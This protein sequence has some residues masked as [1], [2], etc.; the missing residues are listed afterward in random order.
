MTLEGE[1]VRS[2]MKER[3]SV[4]VSG[5]RRSSMMQG[6]RDLA[7][8][9]R[10]HGIAVLRQRSRAMYHLFRRK[11][12]AIGHMIV[13][14]KLW[15]K[16]IEAQVRTE[17]WFLMSEKLLADSSTIVIPDAHEF[18]TLVPITE[19]NVE[20]GKYEEIRFNK[21]HFKFDRRSQKSCLSPTAREFLTTKPAGSRSPT[22]IAEIVR[23][24]KSFASFG[25]FP[26]EL[27]KEIANSAI[28]DCYEKSRILSRC[29]RRPDGWYIVLYGQLLL[30]PKS[31]SGSTEAKVA[32]VGQIIGED[33]VTLNLPRSYT[34]VTKDDNT[35]VLYICKQDYLEAKIRLEGRCG[36]EDV[37]KTFQN[38]PTL[39]HFDFDI[40]LTEEK[41]W[42][43]HTYQTGAIIACQRKENPNDPNIEFTVSNLT[44]SDLMDEH[45]LEKEKSS[46]FC[47]VQKGSADIYGVCSETDLRQK[48][49]HKLALHPSNKKLF[50]FLDPSVN[51]WRKMNR[52]Y[53]DNEDGNL[54]EGF[55]LLLPENWSSDERSCRPLTAPVPRRYQRHTPFMDDP[56]LSTMAPI[57]YQEPSVVGPNPST[58]VNPSWTSDKGTA[59]I[60]VAKIGR[61]EAGSIFGLHGAVKEQ[62]KPWLK[63]GIE[64]GIQ[65]KALGVQTP[66]DVYFVSNGCQVILVKK[67]VYYK[68]L[69]RDAKCITASRVK[70]KN[71]KLENMWFIYFNPSKLF[72]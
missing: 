32:E 8:F 71:K 34:I 23:C 42:Q 35:E 3:L 48:E 13:W 28:L 11:A 66:P 69:E 52:H 27:Q 14:C 18:V 24:L 70:K 31:I 51:E 46:Y 49:R 33:E 53:V 38:N 65:A 29:G 19:G 37:R 16:E 56:E 67:D 40:L 62:L 57:Q 25:R 9:Q 43:V 50:R 1:R 58:F 36:F 30:R 55:M 44:A 20:T 72:L 15:K 2:M 45:A 59:K 6:A 17:D 26:L 39:R 22:E 61:A 21:D 5:R 54:E 12:C 60:R 47:V 63:D 68:G 4:Q 10:R 7:E 41:S 64:V